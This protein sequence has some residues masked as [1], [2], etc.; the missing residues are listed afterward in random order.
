MSN[1][2]PNHWRIT[3]F[4]ACRDVRID[5][6]YWQN[7]ICLHLILLLTL[8]VC[9][10]FNGA[11]DLTTVSLRCF[12]YALDLSLFLKHLPLS[13][14]ATLFLELHNFVHSCHYSCKTQHWPFLGQMSRKL[15]IDVLRHSVPTAQK[16]GA[17][18]GHQRW[19]E[20]SFQWNVAI[21]LS[22]WKK[23][24]HKERSNPHLLMFEIALTGK[25]VPHR[26]VCGPMRSR[27]YFH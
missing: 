15:C 6:W 22:T 24:E 21:I 18:R 4:K 20:S 8:C 26:F 11:C 5:K 25:R 9:D 23:H 1:L 19:P 13:C 27:W 14:P 17:L 3:C 16:L 2:Y 12:P 7:D 10:K